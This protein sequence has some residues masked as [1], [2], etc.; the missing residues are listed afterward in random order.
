MIFAVG[1]LGVGAAVADPTRTTAGPVGMLLML[2]ATASFVRAL[3]RQHGSRARARSG[4][5]MAD[6]LA[7]LPRDGAAAPDRPRDRQGT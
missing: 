7:D 5:E 6:R 1:A 2:F 3:V 4:A